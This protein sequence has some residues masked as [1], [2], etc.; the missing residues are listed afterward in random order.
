VLG[1]LD[2]GSNLIPR[3]TAKLQRSCEVISKSLV[4]RDR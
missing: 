3:V 2:V 1:V 4:I